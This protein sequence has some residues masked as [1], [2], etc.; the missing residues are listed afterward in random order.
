MIQFIDIPQN[1]DEDQKH[2]LMELNRVK[3]G[4]K[5]LIPALIKEGKDMED[6]GEICWTCG[7]EFATSYYTE[8]GKL[9]EQ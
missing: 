5:S 6:I 8:T 9:K 1:I 4:L 3:V 2:Y 7:F